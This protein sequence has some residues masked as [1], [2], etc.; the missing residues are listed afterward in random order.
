MAE[1][2]IYGTFWGKRSGATDPNFG[3]STC[4]HYFQNYFQQMQWKPAKDGNKGKTGWKA[5]RAP[6]NYR[7]AKLDKFKF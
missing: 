7:N 1:Q 3:S 6:R 5:R 2:I 4:H